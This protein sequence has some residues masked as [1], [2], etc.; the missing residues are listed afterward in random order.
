MHP[1]TSL[2]ILVS[3]Y[4]FNTFHCVTLQSIVLTSNTIMY[5]SRFAHLHAI[6]VSIGSHILQVDLQSCSAVWTI[7]RDRMCEFYWPVWYIGQAASWYSPEWR[8]AA[9]TAA[10]SEEQREKQLR[11]SQRQARQ[12]ESNLKAS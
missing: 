11:Y 12:L 4:I 6:I 10:A 5:S 9:A 7:V 1:K 8:L 3:T 2:H